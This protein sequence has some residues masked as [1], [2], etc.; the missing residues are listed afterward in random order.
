MNE[1]ISLDKKDELIDD[2]QTLD[3]FFS[4]VQKL[5]NPMDPVKEENKY[6]LFEDAKLNE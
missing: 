2:T 5:A 3:N 6:T 4:D 1:V